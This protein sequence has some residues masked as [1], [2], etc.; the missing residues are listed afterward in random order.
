MQ[1]DFAQLG[2]GF[3]VVETRIDVDASRQEQSLAAGEKLVHVIDARRGGDEQWDA[4]ASLDGRTVRG[5]GEV[6]HDGDV[7]A[8]VDRAHAENADDRPI[9]RALLWR[10]SATSQAELSRR[11]A[12][13]HGSKFGVRCGCDG[14]WYCRTPPSLAFHEK[15]RCQKSL[16]WANA[17]NG[18]LRS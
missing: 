2:Q 5:I 9:H 6:A 11:L 15:V 13:H 16:S 7:S 18:V 8:R 12:A 1:V 3:F 17:E 10:L 4:A 14:Q